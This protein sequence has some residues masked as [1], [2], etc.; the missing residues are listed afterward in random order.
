MIK[1]V[2]LSTS[3]PIAAFAAA[4]A[5]THFDATPLQMFATYAVTGCAITLWISLITGLRK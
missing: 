5:R 3:I 1:I 4:M 2:A